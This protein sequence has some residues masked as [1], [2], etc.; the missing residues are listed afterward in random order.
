[1]SILR[2]K[3]MNLPTLSFANKLVKPLASLSVTA[4]ALLVA[5]ASLSAQ[6]QCQPVHG[7]IEAR[8]QTPPVCNGDFCSVGDFRGAI[9]GEYVVATT[10]NPEQPVADVYF[11]TGD[12]TAPVRIGD[13]QGTLQIKNTGVFR[14]SGE[15]T[16]LE[17]ITGGTDE[18]AGA[19][20]VLFVSGVSGEE[21]GIFRYEGTVCLP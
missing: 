15:L 1:M 5:V 17:T 19:S 8:A 18:L 2:R 7:Q 16:E 13:R 20:G 12:T 10:L 4:M 6:G 21:T 14:L 11:Y 9:A 3:M